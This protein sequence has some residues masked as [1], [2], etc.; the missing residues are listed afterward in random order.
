M[1]ASP[2]SHLRRLA[3]YQLKSPRYLDDWRMLPLLG[4]IHSIALQ[5]IDRTNLGVARI[6]GMEADLVRI[7]DDS[8]NALRFRAD[9]VP[10]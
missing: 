5:V 1:R 8:K 6:A 3:F 10:G 2:H 9:Y 7:S 4:L